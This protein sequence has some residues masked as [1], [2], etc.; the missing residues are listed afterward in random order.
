M[1]PGTAKEAT[2]TIICFELSMPNVGSWNGRWSGEGRCYVR[3]R[4]FGRSKATK[5]PAVNIL[6]EGSYYY[7]FGD[8]WGAGVSV[9]EVTASEAAKIERKSAGFCGYDWMIDSII[10]DGEILLKPRAA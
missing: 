4:K 7:N 9:R 8:G 1:M 6:A 10:R 5:Q 2:M 3:I